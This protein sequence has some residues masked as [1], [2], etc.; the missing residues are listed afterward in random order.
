M[1]IKT[2]ALS[3]A[4]LFEVAFCQDIT[5]SNTLVNQETPLRFSESV[6]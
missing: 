5:E 4:L 3:V 1:R 6:D 2:I